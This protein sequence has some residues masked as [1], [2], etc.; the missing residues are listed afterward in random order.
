MSL[1]DYQRSQ[2]ICDEPFYVLIMAAMRR[3]DTNNA[4][5]LREAFPGTWRELEAR[6]HAPGGLLDGEIDT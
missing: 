3:A 5:K 2:H 1:Y 4:E 6:Y